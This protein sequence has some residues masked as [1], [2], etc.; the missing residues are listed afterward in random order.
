MTSDLK[1]PCGG[2]PLRNS[3]SLTMPLLL[4]WVIYLLIQDVRASTDHPKTTT[5]TEIPE[6]LT[7]GVVADNEPYSS[8]EGR[9]AKGFSVDVLNELSKTLGIRFDYRVGS[10]PDIYAAFRRGD[11]DIIDEI[12]WR[13]DRAKNI[14]FTSAYHL[15][16]TVVM[17]NSAQ[18]LPTIKTL[19]QLKPYR[20]GIMR[21]IYYRD[22]LVEQG[23]NVIEYDLLPNLVQALAFGWVD[24]I[25]GP[26]I[27]LNYMARREGFFQLEVNTLAPLKG[28]EIED[29]RLGVLKDRPE[30][31]KKLQAGLQSLPAGW[32]QELN[33]RWMQ[34]DGQSPLRQKPL[35]LTRKQQDYL[36]RLPPLRVGLMRDYAP[37]SFSDNGKV[38]GLSVDILYRLQ[39]LTGV[40]FVPVVDQWSNLFQLFKQ[41]ELDLIA[42]IS[43]MPE[44]RAF[45]R[46]TQPYHRIPNVA[47]TRNANFRLNKASDLSGLRIAVGQGV[48]YEAAVRKLFPDQVI[49]YT[50]Q[51]SMFKALMENQVDLVLAALPNGNHWIREL[52]MT[53]VWIAGELRLPGLIGEDLRLGLQPEL[54]PLTEILD[55]AL[56][57]ISQIE[58]RAIEN[59]WLGAKAISD[60]ETRIT[61]SQKEQDLLDHWNYT[62]TYCV[63]PDRYPLE[64]KNR[65]NRHDGMSASLLTILQ[66]KLDN[67]RFEFL[68]TNN[69]QETLLALKSGKCV[70]APMVVPSEK[71]QQN[72]L[73]S[74]SW[75]N[76]S[77]VILGTLGSPFIDSINDLSG[78]RIGIS[79]DSNIQPILQQ[80][81][82]QLKL[83]P[84]DSTLS[85]IQQVREH[86]LYGFIGGLAETSHLLQQE[87]LGDIRVLGRLPVDSNFSVAVHHQYPQLL[88]LINKLLS[89]LNSTELDQIENDWLSIKLEQKT[90]YT[91]LWQLAAA[92]S[93]LFLA[94]FYWNRKLGNLN[95]QL[96]KANEQLAHLSVTDQLTDLGN[97]NYLSQTFEAYMTRCHQ[98]GRTVAIAMVDAD[99]FKRINDN[100]GHDAGDLCLQALAQ[101]MRTQFSQPDDHLIRFGGEE[102]IILTSDSSTERLEARL[103]TLR[104]AIAGHPV[105]QQQRSLHITVSIGAMV[106]PAGHSEQLDLWLK[107]ADHALYQAKNNGRNQLVIYDRTT[108]ASSRET[109]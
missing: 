65:E 11:L 10:W 96:Q 30:L 14:L 74:N 90:D 91:T 29:F 104:L 25:I 84:V 46:F 101:Q 60:N 21:D 26:E 81:Y 77:N 16:Q 76:A 73:F 102:F 66:Q 40:E 23:I 109:P 70:M 43:D 94:L 64:N 48:F 106:G 99:H 13:E 47:F 15:R 41:G 55:Q 98:D 97:R 79:R 88:V 5:Q 37:F 8:I 51:A 42:N 62:I 6:S 18:P 45:T 33:E 85:G 52:G 92:F 86:E 61:L 49:S 20:V 80:R 9:T 68:P 57:D 1:T 87:S 58:K 54:Q 105:L 39:D 32:L 22:Y 71:L 83:I 69:W 72:L 44:R 107:E 56:N 108:L 12:S 89:S 28:M 67:L 100:Y 31:F 4:F 63:H 75:Y 53:D 95:Q 93:L 34:Y 59:R 3:F 7:V 35:Q 103:Q 38:Q 2:R 82:P 17:Q 24:T 36:N 78:K 50:E 19:D 27:T